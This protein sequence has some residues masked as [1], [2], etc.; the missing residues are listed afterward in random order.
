MTNSPLAGAAARPL[1]SA[2]P[3]QTARSIIEAAQD[4]LGH[5]AVGRRID[6]PAIRTA[7]QSAFGVNDAS[8]AW[9]WKTAYEAVEIAQLLFMRRYG[10]AIRARTADPF[11]RLKLIERIAKLAPSQTRRS[12]KMVQYQ[13]FS[14]PLGLAW[15]AGFAAG[16]MP[17]E[18]VLEP[19][20]GTGLLAIQAELGGAT[21]A[22]NEVADTRLALLQ[23]MFGGT[24]I[25]AHDAAQIHDRLDPG[26]MPTCVIMNPPFS[27]ALGVETR[28]A[29][30]AFRHIASAL[31]RLAEGGRLV[32]ITGSS[33]SLDHAAWRDSFVRLQEKARVVFTAPIAGSI[34]AS[35]GTTFATRLTVID[36]RPADDPG[37]VPPSHE[38]AADLPSLLRM[39]VV[40]LPPRVPVKAAPIA[41]SAARSVDAPRRVAP[42][43]V[44]VAAVPT[45]EPTGTVLEYETVDWAATGA[46]RLTDAL[47]EPYALQSIRIDG[48]QSHPT[49][50]VQSAAMASVAPPKPSY[51]PHFP[52][53]LVEQG[54]LSDAQLESVIYAGEAHSAHLAGNWTVDATFDKVEAAPD[55]CDTAVRFRKGWFLGDGTGAGKGRQVAGVLLDNWLKG[56]RRAVWISKSDK[57][58][59]DAQR[60]WRALGQEPLLIQ[61]L[62]RFRQGTPISLDHGILFTTYAT[63]R[64]D[65]RENRVSRVQQIVDWLGTDF[66]GV[67]VF[68]ESHAMQNA[69]GGKSD[70]G[71]SAPS[72]QGRAGLRLQHA[73]P[74]ARVL[75]V[76]AT[77]ATTVENLAYAQRLGLWGGSDFPFD[78]RTDFVAAIEAGGVAAMEVLARDLKALG[79]YAARS[80]SYEGV[81]YELVEHQLTPDQVRIY[82]GYAGAFQVIH[83]NLDAAL[84]AAGV[85]SSSEGTLNRQAKSA[86]RSAFESAKQSFFNHLITAMK[87]PTL[88]RAIEQGL[89]DGHAAVVQIVSTG[90][91]LLS[92]RLA[93]IDPGEWNDISCD[94]T[95]RE[96]VLDY[97]AHSFPT[98]LHETYTDGDGNL[99]SRPAY[100]DAGNVIECRDACH[101]RDRLIEKLASMEPVQGALDQIVQR[102]GTDMVAEV[103]GRS[104]RIVRKVDVDGE[105]FVVENRPGHANLAEAQAF[106]ED[107]KPILVFSDAGGTGRSY[108]ADLGSRNQRL[109]HHYLLEAGWKADTAIQG[110]GRTNRTNQAQPP[111]FRPVATDVQA[112]K[113]FLSTIARRL[114]T[115]GAITRGQRQTGG[116]GL[117]R[118]EDNLESPYA[119]AALRQFYLLIY[120]GKVEHCSLAT[121]EA[122]T[123]LS[124]TDGCGCLKD[125]LPPI[126]T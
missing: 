67:I 40:D 73:L 92:R 41:P 102:F 15:V 84:E 19:S 36:K 18:L 76:S 88:I 79:L 10:P 89:A 7:M 100:D 42:A 11:E 50:L 122:M 47:Y 6:P 93:E 9:D 77:G 12:E 125:D 106:M 119:H 113:R 64:S 109:R 58:L 94:V 69:G 121:F 65:A 97:L 117:F 39:L 38:M 60:D 54:L 87:T 124:L 52:A 101:R 26:V 96:Y 91:A 63:L 86:A 17:G 81:E 107:K 14:T 118:P 31:A 112:E 74:D 105:R 103:T 61:P 111:L 120:A 4:L 28:V 37:S 51:Q 85:T 78:Q 49:H 53:G 68:D 33:C 114:D 21:L 45:V 3:E 104:R 98:Q 56:R 22:L 24:S 2:R 43:K 20:A 32:A 46:D 13:Q 72:Q 115:L 71:D 126:T 70:R 8:G 59:E 29:D 48:A 35:H 25:T 90:E 82:D 80:L 123:G 34:Y 1:A 57:L 23:A 30:A 62:A 116:Q 83:N 108:H 27:A 99:A 5:L 44:K 55:D 16:F 95:P 75:Y 66:D 110:L